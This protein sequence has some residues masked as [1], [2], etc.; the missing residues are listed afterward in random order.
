M[1]TI[2]SRVTDSNSAK[3]APAKK[4]VPARNNWSR[5]LV[6]SESEPEEVELILISE[7]A[8]DDGSDEDMEKSENEFIDDEA[9]EVENY[10]SGDSMDE[11]EK[12]EIE[13]KNILVEYP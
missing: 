2:S 1:P 3:E 9:E 7:D 12:R 4:S 8:S 13:G 6:D 5:K 11:E 10:Q